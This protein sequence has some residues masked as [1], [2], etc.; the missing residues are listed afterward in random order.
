MYFS[1][2]RVSRNCSFL[3]SKHF[4]LFFSAFCLEKVKER[5][6]YRDRDREERQGDRD[7]K[8]DWDWKGLDQLLIPTS[9]NE[10]W[11]GRK[12]WNIPHWKKHRALERNY[13][14]QLTYIEHLICA[15]HFWFFWCWVFHFIL[16]T[17]PW[18]SLTFSNTIMNVDHT[19]KVVIYK[20]LFLLLWERD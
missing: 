17:I 8:R 12:T 15:H 14:L 11:W 16:I 5:E 19:K 6:R 9:Q 3:T 1:Q 20:I 2:K 18:G 13:S 4:L 10:E 7:R